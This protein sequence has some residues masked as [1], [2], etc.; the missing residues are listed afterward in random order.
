MADSS[1]WIFFD[2]LSGFLEDKDPVDNS[3][4]FKGQ[5]MIYPFSIRFQISQV[6]NSEQKSHFSD[7]KE[8]NRAGVRKIVL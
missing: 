5:N 7:K 4:D 2:L 3:V 1:F 6:D 8:M